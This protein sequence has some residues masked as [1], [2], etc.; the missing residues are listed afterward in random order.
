MI[1][2]LSWCWIVISYELADD[3]AFKEWRKHAGLK[4]G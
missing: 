3:E 4:L 2:E 1:I